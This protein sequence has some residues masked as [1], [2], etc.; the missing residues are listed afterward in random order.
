MGYKQT[1][2]T[3]I[4]IILVLIALNVFQYYRSEALINNNHPASAD[5]SFNRQPLDPVK[6][7]I[8]FA[9]E[10][11]AADYKRGVDVN[12]DGLVNCIDAAVLFYQHFPDKSLVS[13]TLNYNPATGMN[14]L[15]NAVNINGT[16]RAIEPQANV[17]NARCYFMTTVWQDEYDYRLNR[18]VTNHY[19]RYVR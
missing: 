1:L 9:L 18:N 13:I 8:N 4:V 17:I 3:C 19:K 7:M 15:F 12:G 2:D 5:F 10:R 11:T 14:H 6:D 16:W